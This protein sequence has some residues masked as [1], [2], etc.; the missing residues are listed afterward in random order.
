ML[1]RILLVFVWILCGNQ[2]SLIARFGFLQW[3]S[4]LVFLF[5][6][7][8]TITVILSMPSL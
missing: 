5:S 3:A 7:E 8:V 2:F 4:S 6:M 1:R